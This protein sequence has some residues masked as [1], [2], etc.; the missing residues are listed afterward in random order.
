[1]ISFN[2][3]SWALNVILLGPLCMKSFAV[4]FGT[5]NFCVVL[6]ESQIPMHSLVGTTFLMHSLVGTTFLM[7]SLVGTTFLAQLMQVY[8]VLRCLTPEI[9]TDWRCSS[10]SSSDEVVSST[11]QGF[12]CHK[13]GNRVG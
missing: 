4:Y 10:S 6:H 13:C 11:I 2:M 7:H 1:M 8:T 9:V 5:D 3:S 12:L